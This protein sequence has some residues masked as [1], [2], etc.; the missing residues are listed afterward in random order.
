MNLKLPKMLL[1][2]SPALSAQVTTRLCHDI[3]TQFILIYSH[4][5]QI[6]PP[7]MVPTQKQCTEIETIRFS[8]TTMVLLLSSPSNSMHSINCNF[9]SWDLDVQ[10]LQPLIFFE[11]CFLP[12]FL[13]EILVYH[14][15]ALEKDLQT[16][17]VLW[18]E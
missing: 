12:G 8:K 9:Y 4:I 10:K 15:V 11:M 7:H 14:S 5:S 13:S 18:R 3:D 17:R 6:P 2:C 16:V 1:T